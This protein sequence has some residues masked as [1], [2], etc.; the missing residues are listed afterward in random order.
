M[1]RDF[2][3]CER[4]QLLLMPPSLVEWLPE[5]HLVWT[6]LGAVDQMD[7]ERFREG[8]RLGGTGRAPYDPAMLVALL[9]Y[10]YARGNRS[11]RRIERACWEDVAY[12]VITSM[13]VPDHSTIAEFRRRHE[14]EIA[15]LFDD[16]LGLCTEAGLVSVGLI[17]I[18]GTKIKANASMDQNRSYSGVVREI[19][20]EAEETDRREDELYGDARGDEL[21]EQLRTA[22]GRKQALADAKRRIEER[23]GRAVGS[24]EP[25]QD[26]EV[27]P[28]LVLGRGGRRGGRR[29]WPRVA[30]RELE[31]RREREAEPIPRDREDRLFQALGRLEENHRVDLA[32]N[33]AYERWRSGSRDTLGRRLKGN[34]KPYAPPDVPEGQI[35]LSDPD[36]RVMRNKGLPHRQAYNVQTAVTEQ[37]II[38]AAEISINAPDFGHLEPTLD[39]ALWHLRRH[40]I[41]EQ[42]QAVVGDAGYWH[43]QQIQAIQDR[44]I[45]VLVP[46]D[47]AMR[48]GNRPG[49]EDGLYEQMREKLK[50]AHGRTFYALRKITIEPVFGQIKYNRRV[51]QFMRRGRA[52]VQS[53]L[54]LVA[55][56]HNLLK[57]HTHWITNTA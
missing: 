27:D 13:R 36:S 7:L 30:R 12:K 52:A 21:P 19:L 53:E 49:W 23:K 34:S 17:M 47:G 55:A 48:E 44:G 22:E 18:D 8:Y 33:D 14:A 37:Q 41:A 45:E 25:G 57:L 11:S 51:D 43:T 31:S 50:T 54:R 4:G 42:P 35:N 3:S 39:Q 32:A 5:D 1:A 9:L 10:A 56:T 15:Q 46:P 29:E 20:R 24:Q 38:L 2:V 26:V 40:G 16:V 28:E 6:V